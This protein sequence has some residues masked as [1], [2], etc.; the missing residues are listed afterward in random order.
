MTNV[1]KILTKGKGMVY[2]PWEKNGW[3]TLAEKLQYKKYKWLV[4]LSQ[5]T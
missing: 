2:V 3:S 4:S 5:N 1:I